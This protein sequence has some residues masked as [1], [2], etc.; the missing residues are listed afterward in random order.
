MSVVSHL[1]NATGSV[2]RVVDPVSDGQGGWTGGTQTVLTFPARLSTLSQ[3]EQLIAAQRN[4]PAQYALYAEP[5][6]FHVLHLQDVVTVTNELGGAIV[7]RL[8]GEEKPSLRDKYA[9]WFGEEVQ[10]G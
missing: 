7:V 1:L 5:E 10:R 4:T 8:V 3:S 9:K 2:T 6:M